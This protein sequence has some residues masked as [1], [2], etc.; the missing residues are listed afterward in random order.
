MNVIV[1]SP[2][3]GEA[4]LDAGSVKMYGEDPSC[5]NFLAKHEEL[6]KKT[7]KLE[8]FVGRVGEFVTLYFVGGHGRMLLPPTASVGWMVLIMY[9][10]M[11]DLVDDETSL[12][13][14]REFTEAGKVVGGVCHG[15]AA[16]V[17]AKL[18]DGSLLV[19]GSEVTGFSNS[20]EDAIGLIPAMTF[21]L[22]TVLNN[23]SGGKYVKAEKDWGEK[24][25]VARDGKLATGQNSISAKGVG[26][27]MLEAVG[28]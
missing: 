4:P 14:I 19:A 27:A 18:S 22:E 21:L 13:L 1:A 15:S 12:R 5:V 23:A 10:A 2:L 7:G 25:V 6:F 8:N 24:V 11:F 3:G 9:T 16:F 17:K 28:A 26:M 20:E